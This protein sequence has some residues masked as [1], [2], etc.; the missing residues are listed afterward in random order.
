M[1]RAVTSFLSPSQWWNPPKKFF[2]KVGVEKAR[3]GAAVPLQLPNL[4]FNVH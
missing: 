1:L 2:K 4:A 3:P